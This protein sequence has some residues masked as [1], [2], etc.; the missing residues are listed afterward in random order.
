MSFDHIF[1]LNLVLNLYY[2]GIIDY[3][4]LNFFDFANFQ[5]F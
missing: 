5:R 4:L 3:F 1:Q 2:F